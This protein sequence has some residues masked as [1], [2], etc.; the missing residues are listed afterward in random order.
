MKK[1]VAYCR[2]STKEQHLGLEAQRATAERYA[3]SVNG[4][5][6]AVYVEQESGKVDSRP[7]LAKAI[8]HCKREGAVLLAAKIDRLSRRV[9]FLFRLKRELTEAGVEIVAADMPEVIK[10]TMSLAVF[11]GIAEKERE[12]I[13]ARTKAALAVKKEQGIKLGNAKGVDM[14]KAQHRAC[15]VVKEQADAWAKTVLPFIL[16]C[17]KNNTSL[18]GTARCLNDA[19]IKTRTGK[20]WTATAVKRALAR[21]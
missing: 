21:A 11:A 13:S 20:M 3:A 1:F 14:S 8:E 6:I 16:V 12:L 10:D 4:S 15:E 2:T 18:Q 5:I 19:G 17:H 9:E 7:E